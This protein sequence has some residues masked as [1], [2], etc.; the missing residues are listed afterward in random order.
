MYG[1][2]EKQKAVLL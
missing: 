2:K 1:N